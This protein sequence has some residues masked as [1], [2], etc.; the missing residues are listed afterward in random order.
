MVRP[1]NSTTIVGRYAYA[2]Y[3]EG[4]L[5][6]MNVAGYPRQRVTGTQSGYKGSLAF[7]D[8]TQIG[9]TQPQIDAL[10][11]WRNYASAQ[12]SGSFP[13]ITCSGTSYYNYVLGNTFG[14]LTVGNQSLVNGQSDRMFSSRQQLINLV[15]ATATMGGNTAAT[16]NALQYLGTFSRD[17]EQPSFVPN[18]ARPLVQSGVAGSSASSNIGTFGTGNDAFGLDRTGTPSGDINPPFLEVRVSGTFTRSDGTLAQVGEPLVKKRFPLSRL[19]LLTTGATAVQSQS[20]PIYRNFGLYRTSG[21]SPWL[22]NHGNTTGIY[23]LSQIAALTGTNAREPD[24]FE[25]LKAAINVGSLGKAACYSGNTMTINGN[26]VSFNY[27]NAGTAGYLQAAR[28]NITTL[29]ILQIGANI[30]DQAKADDFPTRIQFAGDINNPPY[31]VRGVEDLPYFYRI[32]N[33]VMRTGTSG[34]LGVI[35]FQPELW[36]PHSYPGSSAGLSGTAIPTSFRVRAQTDPSVS[37]S[38][39]LTGIQAVYSD[40]NA[41]A[42]Y[43]SISSFNTGV[44]PAPLTFNAGEINGY[45]G[46]RE[47]TLLMQIGVPSSSNLS[48]TSYMDYPAYTPQPARQ[49]TGLYVTS[50]PWLDGTNTSSVCAKVW[51]QDNGQASCLR[52][53][54][55]YQDPNGNWI[56]YDEQPFQPY[57]SFTMITWPQSSAAQQLA[58]QQEATSDYYGGSRTDP[59]TSRWGLFISEYL[60]ALPVISSANNEYATFRPDAG[61][62][63]GSHVGGRND[64]GIVGAGNSYPKVDRGFQHGYWTENSVRATYQ[65]DSGDNGLRY[66]R[67]P[68]GVPRRA[69]GGYWSDTTNGG[70]SGT[71][72]A[73]SPVVGLP[74]ATANYSSRPTILHRPF[75]SVAELG[76]VFSD[77]PWRNLDLSFPESGDSPLLDVFCI[78][79]NTNPT[80]LVAGRVDLNTRQAPVVQALLSGVIIDKDSNPVVSSTLSSTQLAAIA[81]QLVARTSGTS[82]LSGTTYWTAPLPLTNRGDLVG[83]CMFSGTTPALAKAALTGTADPNPYY[84]GF[85]ADIGTVSGVDGTPVSLVPRQRESIMR[86]LA[87]S[88]TSR[89]WNL[90]IDVIAQS[91][92]YPA[93]AQDISAGFVVEG[94]KRYW[95]HVAIDRYTGQVLDEQLEPVTE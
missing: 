86:A 1:R 28:D 64:S 94:E 36:N 45:W 50:F 12:A 3:D 6:D 58:L 53:Y 15:E 33:W 66:T 95:L 43:S 40:N 27:Y 65:T 69:M 87:D 56:T 30:I 41:S 89:V 32:R 92:R 42:D 68:D 81:A 84:S 2:I 46:F 61:I 75:R 19:S 5:L 90:M 59:R 67:D 21:T 4:G 47:P 17:L 39:P 71:S 83:S 37:G 14:F 80:G 34:A 48:G 13:N 82:L 62:S 73:T 76:Y 55:D 63:Y 77:N 16:I 11:G 38:A 93:S 72:G 22:Y 51:T 88:G 9:L 10:V 60:Y 54:L 52:F 49:V 20:D 57:D 79:E 91:G 35:L 70:T 7:A 24:F 78:N 74:M 31:Q 25:L 29:Q 8:L 85:S 18:P 26:S 44:W 23:R